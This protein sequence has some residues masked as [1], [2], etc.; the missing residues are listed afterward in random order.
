M[1]RT[2]TKRRIIFT[3]TSHCE[4]EARGNPDMLKRAIVE[5]HIA[6]AL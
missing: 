2:K 5:T 3:H 1:T 4:G 6:V